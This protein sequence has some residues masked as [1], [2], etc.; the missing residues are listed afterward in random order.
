MI[1]RDELLAVHRRL[2]A[3][4]VTASSDLFREV[5]AA[6]T[7]AVFKRTA[8][9][10]SWEAATDRATDAIVE[11]AKSPGRFDP[12][13]SGLFGYLLLIARRDAL[14]VVR[15]EQTGRKRDGWLVELSVSDGNTVEEAPDLR[16]DAARI[17]TDHQAELVRD[18]GDEAIL[19]LYLQG[20][21]DTEAYANALGLTGVPPADQR[22]IVKT[23][24]DRLEQRLRRLREVLK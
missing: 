22:K 19:R 13:R 24:K 2:L 6:L 5:H 11:Y 18:D 23:R 3:G 8:P 12:S 7:A 4:D 20:E 21:K 14:N 15:S 16:L 10:L 9:G 1:D 17:L